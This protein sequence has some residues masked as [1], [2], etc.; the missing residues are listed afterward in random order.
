LLKDVIGRTLEP[1]LTD[2]RS[3]RRIEIVG[4]P[5]QLNPQAAVALNMAFHELVTNAAKYG[6]LS[7]PGG[8]VRVAWTVDPSL[9]PLGIE[10]EWSEQGGPPVA[11]P[12]RR[13][14]GS[15][16]LEAGLSHELDGEVTMNFAPEG[17][18]CRMRYSASDRMYPLP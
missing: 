7:A 18:V 9:Q 3:H 6:A 10:I 17:L 13:G 1:Y 12:R 15:H 14:F 2:A 4:P 16:V 8:A 5:V 11:P